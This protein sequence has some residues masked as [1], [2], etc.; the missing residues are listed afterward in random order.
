MLLATS[1]DTRLLPICN[2]ASLLGHVKLMPGC[3]HTCAEQCAQEPLKFFLA[4]GAGALFPVAVLVLR[5]YL[6]RKHKHVGILQGLLV[7]S[8]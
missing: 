4:A 1:R 2:L 8:K 6:V 7:G 3:A 5:M